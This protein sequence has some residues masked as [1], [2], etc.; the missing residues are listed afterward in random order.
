[1]TLQLPGDIDKEAEAKKGLVKLM[2]SRR[3]G[4]STTTTTMM[5]AEG[6]VQ[7]GQRLGG[8]GGKG[9]TKVMIV[10]G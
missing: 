5:I 4:I 6:E 2:L 7:H 9:T 10:G 8:K 3:G 1:M